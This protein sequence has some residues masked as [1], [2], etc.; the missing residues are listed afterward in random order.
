M[1]SVRGRL[2]AMGAAIVALHVV[3][4]GLLLLAVDGPAR[5]LTAFGVGTGVLA[6]TLGMRH[7]FDVDHIAAIDNVTR[8]L[9]GDGQKPVAV[10]FAFSLGHSTVVLVL[11]L[12]L[13]LG[14]RT[15][16]VEVARDGSLL[17]EVTGTIGPV[18][19]SV[20]LLAVAAINLLAARALLRYRR[21]ARAGTAVAAGGPPGGPLMRLLAR[22]AAAID[23]SWKMYPLG[24]L[25]GLGFDTAT[26]VGLLVLAGTGVVADLPIWAVLSLPI[27]FAAGMSL[28]D[29]LDGAFMNAAYGW[30]ASDPVRR[31]S[32]DLTITGF[33]VL[34]AVVVAVIQL[35][36]VA[37]ERLGWPTGPLSGLDTG[38]AG[39]VV[40]GLFA[41][42]WL[43]AL[44]ASRPG[45]RVRTRAAR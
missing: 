22:P 27:L 14:V 39:Y 19:S 37:Q 3:G 21:Q 28:M 17:H 25:F 20:F 40:V 34:V 9:R 33:S 4:F 10:G 43:G 18:V 5:G 2:V 1:T 36:Q 42:F 8:R 6:Y 13:A 12:L 45:V 38:D 31:V 7:A 15:L 24:F 23:R 26:E 30:S 44:V 41:L 11:V 32:Y 29:S 16:G 35:A